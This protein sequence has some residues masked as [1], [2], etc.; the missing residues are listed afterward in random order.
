[1]L[2]LINDTVLGV[3]RELSA[4]ILAL[5]VLFAIMNVTIFLELLGCTLWTR[6]SDAHRFL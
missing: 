5:M 6:L 2:A 3:Q 1:V 4:T